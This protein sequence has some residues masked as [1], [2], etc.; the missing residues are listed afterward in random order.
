L[1]RQRG[2][3][4]D[5]DPDPRDA[6]REAGRGA[7]AKTRSRCRRGS[8]RRESEG[9][10]PKSGK[11]NGGPSPTKIRE[12]S[13]KLPSPPQYATCLGARRKPS[14]SWWD[15]H[16]DSDSTQFEVQSSGETGL[17]G[18]SSES[19]RDTGFELP[20]GFAGVASFGYSSDGLPWRIRGD[21]SGG[22][23]ALVPG[24]LARIGSADGPAETQPEFTPFLETFY[25]DVT[26]YARQYGKF[27]DDVKQK[28]NSRVQPSTTVKTTV[29]Q[30]SVPWAFQGAAVG[31]QGT[32]DGS[33]V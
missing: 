5:G 8:G 27:R 12:T 20:D 21:K 4:D 9:Q 18:S 6:A 30:R 28:K 22:M 16:P 24:G 2:G 17:G 29:C 32:A 15:R 31:R 11:A 3:T 7:S 33:R 13:L 14:C 23:M 1:R 25:M 26:E 10:P 19:P